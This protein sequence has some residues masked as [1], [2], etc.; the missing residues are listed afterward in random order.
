MWELKSVVESNVES[1]EDGVSFDLFR[2]GFLILSTIIPPPMK[3]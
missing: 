3:R 1:M 2:L